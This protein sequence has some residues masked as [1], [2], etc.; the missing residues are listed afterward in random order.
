MNEA[1]NIRMVRFFRWLCDHK[2]LAFWDAENELDLLEQIVVKTDTRMVSAASARGYSRHCATQL[3]KQNVFSLFPGEYTEVCRVLEDFVAFAESESKVSASAPWSVQNCLY[4]TVGSDSVE[5]EEPF[6]TLGDLYEKEL[7]VA[8][9][10][11]EALRDSFA[12]A[13]RQQTDVKSIFQSFRKKL[14]LGTE[15]TTTRNTTREAYLSPEEEMRYRR[16]RNKILRSFDEE[17]EAEKIHYIGE[18]EISDEEYSLLLEFTRHQLEHHNQYAPGIGDS[19]LIATALVQI[20]I[21]TY[22]GRYWPHAAKELGMKALSTKFQRFLNETF[23]N[24]ARK[25]GFLLLS[26]SQTESRAFQS[27]LF[28][29]IVSNYYVPSLFNLLFQYYDQELGRNL[30][31]NTP[32]RMKTLL[33]MLRQQEA[34]EEDANS[35]FPGGSGGASKAYRLR[36]HTLMALTAF[37]EVNVPRLIRYVEMIDAAFWHQKLPE[38]GVSRLT[39]RFRDWVE[40]SPEMRA[41]YRLRN[42]KTGP[43]QRRRYFQTPYLHVNLQNGF[44]E[45]RLPE[46][47]LRQPSQTGRVVWSIQGNGLRETFPCETVEVL[48]GHKTESLRFNIASTA[49]LSEIVCNLYV[50]DCVLNRFK[51]PAVSARFFDREGDQENTLSPGEFVGFTAVSDCL[52]SAALLGDEI[53]GGLHRWEFSFEE[54]DFVLL[55]DGTSFCIGGNYT[56]GLLHRGRVPAVMCE[57][58]SSALLPI[59]NIA[60]DLLLQVEEDKMEGIALFVNATRYRLTDC[61]LKYVGKSNQGGKIWILLST[62]YFPEIQNNT[63]NSLVLEL[64][65][66]AFARSPIA[67]ALCEGLK[68][69]FEDAPYIFEE[70]GTI[71]FSSEVK[72]ERAPGTN[73]N[74]STEGNSFNFELAQPDGKLHFV[75]FQGKLPIV[76]DIPALSWCEVE[77]HWHLAPLGDIWVR[78]F[79]FALSLRGPFQ[80]VGFDFGISPDS[81]NGTKVGA[82]LF[83]KNAQTGIFRCDLTRARSW[84][85]RDRVCYPVKLLLDG[86]SVPFGRI[87]AK[88]LLLSDKIEL[89]ANFE[90]QTLTLLCDI[91]GRNKEYYADICNK[92]SGQLLASK[93]P[94]NGKRLEL[95][96]GIPNGEYEVTVYETDDDDFFDDT[97]YV[98]GAH[99][100]TLLD[101]DNLNG[102]QIRLKYISRR[103]YGSFRLPLKGNQRV[104]RLQRQSPQIYKAVLIDEDAP[105]K[106]PYHVQLILPDT[107]ELS[108]FFLKYWDE[109]Y[110]EYYE[111]DYDRKENLLLTDAEEQKSLPYNL[112]YRRYTTL[113]DDQDEFVGTFEDEPSLS[114]IE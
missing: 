16:L 25:H 40:K 99:S 9:R 52:Q 7:R 74:R 108:R 18:I 68:V 110:D 31:Q 96:C 107:E 22:D 102:K 77:D 101:R 11:L 19:P 78:D 97:Y 89:M 63:L 45:L 5:K 41:Q 49:V 106:K 53:I 75:L 71:V 50:D 85:S 30:E 80:T 113:F 88:S 48:C 6:P 26:D 82:L 95:H 65:G 15:G 59:Y 28:H 33:D 98:L 60:P 42:E 13:N 70:R 3:V 109:A 62:S 94:F 29:C 4:D 43:V 51:I 8:G 79:P 37:P 27:I 84:I 100:C 17:N 67:F 64:P 34:S 36:K 32:E 111:F 54:G 12:G 46:Q 39:E 35:T 57:G 56:E 69:T 2:K 76:V 55:P 93:M 112:R 66:A 38:T 104:C 20:G 81:M 73:Y 114:E 91:L 1:E 86:K 83:E 90:E 103:L 61:N 105:S 47:L 10:I 21:R 87:F 14:S 72:V 24:T 23:Q 58:L 44:F 92:D